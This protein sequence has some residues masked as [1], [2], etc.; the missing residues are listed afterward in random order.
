MWNHPLWWWPW[1]WLVTVW[2]CLFYPS[3]LA[4]DRSMSRY[5]AWAQ[6]TAHT[7]DLYWGLW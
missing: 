7:G 5:P 2:T 4:K 6:Y 3:W 1:L